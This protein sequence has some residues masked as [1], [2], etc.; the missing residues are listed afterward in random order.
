MAEHLD[1]DRRYD[2]FDTPPVSLDVF[3]YD[4]AYLN[5]GITLGP[6]QIEV[7]KHSTQIYR[8]AE[9]ETLKW[10]IERYVNEL[11]L[12]WGKGSGKD[13]ISQLTAARIA[14]L[15]LCLKDP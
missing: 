5:I 3:L 8:C 10:K 6:K 12:E 1:R 11:Y 9:L 7:L 15:L 4:R 14:N 13:L 2:M